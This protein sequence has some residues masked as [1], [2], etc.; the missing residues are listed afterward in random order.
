M[1]E[2]E[3]KGS[4]FKRSVRV[5]GPGGPSSGRHPRTR[6]V[7]DRDGAVILYG[8]HTVSA[9]LKNPARRI[10]RLWATENAVRRLADEG[11]SCA[12]DPELAKPGR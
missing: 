1:R 10:R 3:K 12:V 11:I 2:G 9:A 6:A 5:R 8:W 4:K 7:H